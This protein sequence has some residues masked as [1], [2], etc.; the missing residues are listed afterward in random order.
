[1]TSRMGFC[2]ATLAA[3]CASIVCAS[4][5]LQVAKAQA[6]KTLAAA[7][8]G[9]RNE[10]GLAIGRNPYTANAD[11][12]AEGKDLFESNACSGCHGVN[13]GG[14][15]CPSLV[16]AIWIYGSDDTTLFNLIKLGSV[17]LRAQ[18]YARVGHEK[19]GGDMPPFASMLSEDDEWKLIAYIRSKY[20]GDPALRNW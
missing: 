2:I 19:V 20:T 16:N 6:V 4:C 18:D 11:A 14:G 5:L 12:I 8:A 3:A 13:A 10:R 9:P 17:A 15:I 7:A 1:M